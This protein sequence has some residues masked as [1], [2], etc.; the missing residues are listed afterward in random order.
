MSEPGP[1]R[2]DGPRRTRIVAIL[3]AVLMI[4]V[5]V[6][7]ARFGGPTF[8][9]ISQ[10]TNNDQASYLPASA[11]STAVQAEQRRFYGAA[12]IPA[13]VLFVR[14]RG[15]TVRDRAAVAAE[16]ARLATVAGVD[17]VSPPI[18]SADG[19][20]VQLIVAVRSAADGGTVVTAMRTS[21]AAHTVQGLRSWVTGPVAIGADFGAGFGGIDGVLLLVALAAVLVILLLVYRSL[22]L[23]VVVL[24]TS[25]FALTGSILVVY[26][27][28][29]AGWVTVTGETRG[30]LAILAIGAA[31][32][33]SLL[34]VSRYRGALVLGLEPV[35]ALLRAWRRSIA[36]VGASAATVVLAVLCLGF[37]DLSSNKGL[38]PVA[39]IA[40]AFAFLSAV[41]ALPAML[42]LLGR[43]AFWPF[44]PRP[45]R[46]AAEDSSRLWARIGRLVGRHPRRVWIVTAVALG[47]MATGLV[48][49]RA[50]GVP[51]TDLLLTPSQSVAGQRELARHYDAGSGSPVVI[52]AS[53]ARRASVARLAERAPRV[54]SVA[55]F[56][57]DRSPA[58]AAPPKV[59]GGMVLLEATLDV[60]PDS[61]TAQHT[62]AVLRTE[63]A[64]VDPSAQVGGT[65]ALDL[66]SNTAAQH[67]LAIVLPIVLAVILVVLVLLLRSLVAPLILIASVVLSYSAT[68][69][70][71]ALAFDDVLRF[72]GADPSVPLFGFVFLVALG[73][74]YNIFLVTRVREECMVRGH[75]A[76]VLAGLQATGGVITSAGVVLAA[77]FAALTTIPI[78]FLVQIAL[79]VAFGVLLD[80]VVVR[81]L[82]VPA[83][84][85]DVGPAFWWPS[86]IAR[87]DATEGLRR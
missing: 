32:D 11:E 37:S 38:G 86:R 66:D 33:Y 74:D 12:T 23:P 53:A 48:G 24:A 14:A 40:V 15:L 69:G 65:S 70:V 8:G 60:A 9:T 71:A 16:S 31:T 49:L 61:E 64:S 73:V 58:S 67:D 72:P 28:A 63:L 81:S 3:G 22:L 50:G 42:A 17:S 26:G 83:V 52:I 20:A 5:W 45:A 59:V 21:L 25:G 76:G 1:D 34:L 82:L 84:A 75:R 85:I 57:G 54:A 27:I 44:V 30:I 29:E 68:L 77:T 18:P 35:P 56:T 41:T 62:V 43:A 55:V 2:V 78:L 4:A 46:S 7:V 10:V 39:A 80:T 87:T 19:K 6:A 13:N 47:A 51:Q 36:P 79:V